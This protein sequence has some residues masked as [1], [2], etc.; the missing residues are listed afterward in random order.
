MLSTVRQVIAHQGDAMD[1]ELAAIERELF[2][3]KEEVGQQ[4][5]G[6]PYYRDNRD[7][8]CVAFRCA[9]GVYVLTATSGGCSA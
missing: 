6:Q 8:L 4:A 7:N 5:G 1:P 3:E 9:W 2:T